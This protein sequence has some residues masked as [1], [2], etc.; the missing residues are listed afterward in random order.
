LD[1]LTN[2]S[3]VLNTSNERSV[4][5]LA[6]APMWST[7]FFLAL[8]SLAN[9][10]RPTNKEWKEQ[11]A[12]DEL[13]AAQEAADAGKR[14]AVDK[15]IAMLEELSA[16]VQ[17]EGEEEAASYNKFACFCKDNQREKN[18][19]IKE[20]K[21]AKEELSAAINKLSAGRKA[22][23]KTIAGLEKDIEDLEKAMKKAN[24]E[25]AKEVKTYTDSAADLSFAIESIQNALKTLKASKPS[26][27][28]LQSASDAVREAVAM[29]DAM[30]L[31][32]D[33]LQG[34]AAALLQDVPVEMENYKFHSDGVIGTIEKLLG[35]FRG[36]KAKLDEEE[37]K[38][39]QEHTMDMQ[40]KTDKVKAKNVRLSDTEK[41]RD[42]KIAEIAESS[43]KLTT[44]S[45]DLL[46]DQY[47]LKELYTMCSQKADSWDKRSKVRADELSAL[48]AAI[49]IIKG[50]VLEKTS[51]AS[52]R[53]AQRGVS[54]RLAE[55]IASD[56]ASMDA[57]E[58]AAEEKDAQSSPAMTFLQQRSASR[59]SPNQDGAEAVDRISKLLRTVAGK[60]K[61]TLLTGLATEI[62]TEKPKGMEK[63]K[64]LIEELINRLQAEAANEATQ[65]GW[66]DKSLA[67]ANQKQISTRSTV[68]ELNDSL[69]KLEADRQLL[70][71]M[72]DKLADE[73]QELNDAQDEAD[74]LR[75]KEKGENEN[76][77]KEAEEGQKAVE[78]AIDIL[79]KFYKGAAKNKDEDAKAK[80]DAPDAGF[81][82]GEAYKGDQSSA[83]GVLGMLDVI[84]SDF[85]RT[86]KETKKSEE[87]A[88][89]D[90]KAFTD[91]TTTSLKE[92]EAIEK[93][94]KKEKSDA[95]SKF[96]KQK[97]TLGKKMDLLV[98]TVEEL[99]ELK[100]ACI[101][102]GMSYEE[103]EARRAE[104]IA[105][106]RKALCI[107]TA[108]ANYGP[109]AAEYDQC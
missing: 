38:R 62:S 77:V 71:E 100:K 72:L 43:Q 93:A 42:D 85:V 68:D 8:L 45:S 30:G 102:T 13:K 36:K 101:D 31:G 82:N 97:E 9:S 12:A 14:S 90:H 98:T 39:V 7:V 83:S 94:R 41:A 75:K 25:N 35:T 51:R 63:I 6:I 18:K 15:V 73:I 48:T 108:Y 67:D 50:A 88:E 80:V 107:L 44:A 105:A 27:L 87:E 47:Y 74:K 106:L 26:L 65:K 17:A 22:D 53:L 1:V 79:E 86:I 76:T 20:N 11:R 95:D 52:V 57:V 21:D 96:D 66:C 56:E 61:S 64:T 46:D 92:K 59:H 49:T 24:E 104:E 34:P 89:Q 84:K 29:A 28:Q 23:D 70:T 99:L 60:T 55:V 32:V 37:V 40:E 16:K 103:R 109:N 5:V 3:A 91:E 69:A 78:S 33:S 4:A 19:S 58:E 54:I 81:E 10:Q 2:G